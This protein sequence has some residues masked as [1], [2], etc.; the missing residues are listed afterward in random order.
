MYWFPLRCH[1]NLFQNDTILSPL[2]PIAKKHAMIIAIYTKT[3]LS[4]LIKMIIHH[5]EAI[6]SP[7]TA[8]V[9]TRWRQSLGARR[10]FSST[11][12]SWLMHVVHSRLPNRFSPQTENKYFIKLLPQCRRFLFE[13]TFAVTIR[14]L[15]LLPRQIASKRGRAWI[16]AIDINLQP[17]IA[18][19]CRRAI[20]VRLYDR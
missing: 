15:V 17:Y 9:Y 3:R 16:K 1:W 8:I 14:A 6:N 12:L 4:T 2:N 20:L 11:Y 18:A 5:Y 19:A 13:D 10:V 7:P